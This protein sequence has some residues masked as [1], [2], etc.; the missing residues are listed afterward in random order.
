MPT[1]SLQRLNLH[2]SVSEFYISNAIKSE[3]T[4]T[5]YK[6][7]DKGIKNNQQ[8]NNFENDRVCSSEYTN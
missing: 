1:I 7:Q 8:R 3:A 5:K 4:E 2:L 6:V